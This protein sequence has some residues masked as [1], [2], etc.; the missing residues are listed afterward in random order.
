MLDSVLMFYMHYPV[1]VGQGWKEERQ[2]MVLQD[3]ISSKGYLPKSIYATPRVFDLLLK[4]LGK[5]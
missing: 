5:Q 1:E 4:A 3:G 2:D